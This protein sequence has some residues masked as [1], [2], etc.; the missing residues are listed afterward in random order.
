M[1]G[2][3]NLAKLLL[4]K[5][6]T[7]WIF[8][9]IK[10]CLMIVSNKKRLLVP[11]FS[12]V[13]LASCGG[14]GSETSNTPK[15][16][17]PVVITPVEQSSWVANNG[18]IDFISC[19]SSC[20]ILVKVDKSGDLITYDLSEDHTIP[21]A[22]E[23]HNVSLAH[24]SSSQSYYSDNEITQR[25]VGG[26]EVNNSTVDVIN[27][28]SNFFHKIDNTAWTVSTSFRRSEYGQIM[29]K[30]ELSYSVS[31]SGD[32]DDVIL[33][34][35]Y[36]SDVITDGLCTYYSSD[37]V[38]GHDFDERIKKF[39]TMNINTLDQDWAVLIQNEFLGYMGIL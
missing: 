20:D 23:F 14:G 27:A 13:V 7:K 18:H 2:I 6:E 4:F 3:S 35:N 30:I 37:Y 9:Q 29:N 28:N 36:R 21:L 11:I 5:N 39:D 25:G 33:K 19:I 12:S 34:C 38:I 26:N 17:P 32:V 24:S 1:K 22:T 10:E 8:K 16:I 15:E 31:V